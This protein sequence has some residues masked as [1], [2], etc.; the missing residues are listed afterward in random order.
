MYNRVDVAFN[1]IG[2]KG[3]YHGIYGLEDGFH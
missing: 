2:R 1:G 3:I